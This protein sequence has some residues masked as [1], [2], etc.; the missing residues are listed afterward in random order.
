MGSTDQPAVTPQPFVPLHCHSYYSLLDGLASP[1]ALVARAAELGCKAMALTDHGTCGGLYDF[2]LAAAKAGIKPILGTEAYI[3][4]NM[5]ARNKDDRRHHITL[6]AKDAEGYRNLIGLST[7]SYVKGHYVKPRIDFDTLNAMRK[8]LMAGTAC[9]KGLV[10]DAVLAGDTGKAEA[11]ARRL[12]DIFGDDL[13]CEIM[14]HQY[15][16]GARE[17]QE[18]FIR[19]MKGVLAIADAHLNAKANRHV[20]FRLDLEQ[21][22]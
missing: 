7:L 15:A 11:M 19:A 16:P 10:A 3:V 8:G 2:Q 22:R 14:I 5:T 17:K 18:S 21:L 20:R 12:K 6:W 13:Y 1:E 4:D 9:M